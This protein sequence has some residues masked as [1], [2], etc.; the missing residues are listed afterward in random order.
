MGKKVPMVFLK[1]RRKIRGKQNGFRLC[2]VPRK[3]EGKYKGNKI[4]RKSKKKEKVKEN[5]KKSIHDVLKR[6]RIEM[7]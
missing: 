2:L 4:Q 7:L 1:T 3:F 6:K 5:K